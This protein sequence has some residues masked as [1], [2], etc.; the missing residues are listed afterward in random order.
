MYIFACI[1]VQTIHVRLVSLYYFILFI[2]HGRYENNQ[3]GNIEII[4]VNLKIS[5]SKAIKSTYQLKNVEQAN[6]GLDL[7][8]I[9]S[10]SSVIE[11]SQLLTFVMQLMMLLKRLEIQGRISRVFLSIFF[12]LVFYYWSGRI[13]FTLKIDVCHAK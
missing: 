7:Q 10:W 5:R 11:K 9:L 1:C 13:F 8:T 4:S 6:P 12:L 2:V 3:T